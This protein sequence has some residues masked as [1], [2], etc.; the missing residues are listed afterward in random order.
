MIRETPK[1][2][3]LRKAREGKQFEELKLQSMSVR[4]RGEYL[5]KERKRKAKEASQS[6]KKQIG[7]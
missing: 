5:E 7:N 6:K 3:E 2:A 4:E 1:E